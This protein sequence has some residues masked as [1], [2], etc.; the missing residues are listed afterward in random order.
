MVRVAAARRVS[1]LNQVGHGMIA[2]RQLRKQIARDEQPE[3]PGHL[4]L[5]TLD[6]RGAQYPKE[7]L[8]PRRHKH[9]GVK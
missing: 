5:F 2:L 6:E 8:K 3:R 1:R 7:P 4:V 9:G